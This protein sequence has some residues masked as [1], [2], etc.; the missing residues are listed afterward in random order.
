MSYGLSEN[1]LYGTSRKLLGET[2][3]D[4]QKRRQL[5]ESGRQ[6]DVSA[7]QSAQEMA[8]QSNQ[9]RQRLQLDQMVAERRQEDTVAE[10]MERARKELESKKRQ[11]ELDRI[12]KEKRDLEKTE[13]ERQKTERERESKERE[14]KKTKDADQLRRFTE[15]VTLKSQYE[16]KGLPLPPELKYKMEQLQGEVRLGGKTTLPDVYANNAVKAKI[17]RQKQIKEELELNEAFMARLDAAEK[18]QWLR[19]ESREEKE[20]YRRKKKQYQSEREKLLKELEG[21][22]AGTSSATLT[23]IPGSTTGST[24][25]NIFN[26]YGF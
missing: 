4:E 16:N 18:P 21:L 22:M 11:G 7:A 26:K 8:Q 3:T 1:V 13:R 17:A 19:L 15:L 10:L 12:S 23:G 5:A 9:A 14:E 2:I 24:A 6:F 25:E 20:A